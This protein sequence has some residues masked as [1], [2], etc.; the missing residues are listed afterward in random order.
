MRNVLAEQSNKGKTISQ[1]KARLDRVT[2]QVPRID[3]RRVEERNGMRS[4]H[5]AA[6]IG[7]FFIHPFTNNNATIKKQVFND[8]E[9]QT[10]TQLAKEYHFFLK[11]KGLKKERNK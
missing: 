11:R 4:K 1:G 5:S 8:L 6:Q 9:S 3:E 10:S 2:N 7:K